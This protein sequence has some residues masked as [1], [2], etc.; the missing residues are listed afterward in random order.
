MSVLEVEQLLLR[1]TMFVH[2]GQQ[3]TRTSVLPKSG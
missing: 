1:S 3:V 2:G